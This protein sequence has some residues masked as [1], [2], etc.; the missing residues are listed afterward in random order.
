[1]NLQERIIQRQFVSISVSDLSILKWITALGEKSSN[2]GINY[3]SYVTAV[4][5]WQE[6]KGSLLIAL[7]QSTTSWSPCRPAEGTRLHRRRGP[8]VWPTVSSIRLSEGPQKLPEDWLIKSWFWV[9]LQIVCVCACVLESELDTLQLSASQ[10]TGPCTDC[11]KW[12]HCSSV[13][14]FNSY[15]YFSIH[16]LTFR[17]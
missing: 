9:Q 4:G 8:T 10:S 5:P 13:H 6:L 7:T 14:Q 12:F 16:L 1:M 3:C 15:C 11:I 17:L 2:F